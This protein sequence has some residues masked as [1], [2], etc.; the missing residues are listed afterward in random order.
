MIGKNS[1]DCSFSSQASHQVLQVRKSRFVGLCRP[2]GRGA[3]GI[4]SWHLSTIGLRRAVLGP[5]IILMMIFSLFTA[6]TP[7]GRA[8][9]PFDHVVV[10][11]LENKSLSQIYGPAPY[12][13]SLSDTYS[14]AQ[15][16]TAIDHPS[17]PNYLAMFSGLAGDCNNG[18]YTIGGC[19]TGGASSTSDCSPSSTCTMGN[20]TNLVDSLEGA[21]KTWSA[22]AEDLSTPCSGAS[23]TYPSFT[24]SR[25][26][27]FY[28]FTDITWSASRC[29]RIHHATAGTDIEMINELNGANP[30]NFVWLTPNLCNDM[31]DCSVSTG[32]NYLKNVVPNILN[33]NTFK[34]AQA[35]LFIV[36]DEGTAT[37]PSDYI[38]AVWAGPA[39]KLGY[40]STTQYTH[41]SFLKTLET[42]WGM[43][44]LVST[45]A[46]ASAMMEFFGSSPPPS[47]TVSFTYTPTPISVGTSVTFTGSVTGG[48]SPY[49]FSWNFGDGSTSSIN[50]T[51]HSYGSSGAY[52]VTLSVTDSV[53]NTGSATNTLTISSL[54]TT[55]PPIVLAR[56]Y[57]GTFYYPWYG[58]SPWRHWN[59]LGHSPPTTWASMYLPDDGSNVYNPSAELYS[60]TSTITVNRHLS[61]MNDARFDF[62]LVSWWGQGSYEDAALRLMLT[63]DSQNSSSTV[64]LAVYY[65]QEG[66]SDPTVS[67]LVSD[68]T[69]LYDNRANSTAYFTVS[70][71]TRSFPVVFVYAGATDAATYV[72]R[73]SQ[74][75][76]QM[77]AIGKPVYIALKVF[78]GYGSYATMV[79]DWYQYAP[80]KSY[81]LQTGYSAF[82]SPG[83]WEFP[84]LAVSRGHCSSP[85]SGG[86]VGLARNATQF[87]S[88]IATMNSLSP[89]QAQFLLVETFNEFH[90]GSQ[91][92]PAFLINHVETGFSQA[93]P[94]YSFSFIDIVKGRGGN[95]PPALSVPGPQSVNVGSPISFSISATDPDSP[96]QTLSLSASGLPTNASF[97]TASGIGSVTGTFS[98]TP[99]SIQVGVYT[100]TFTV[101]DNGSPPLSTINTVSITVLPL[102]SYPPVLGTIGNK[103]VNEQTLLTFTATATDL[104][105]DTLTFSIGAGAPTGAAITSSGVFTWTP[106]EAQGPGVYTV[107]IIVTDSGSPPASDSKTITITVNEVNQ[108]PV[109][110]VPGGQTVDEGV[111]L[112]FTISATDPDIP[113]ETISFSATGLPAGGAFNPLTRTFSWTPSEAQGPGGYTITFTVTDSGSPVLSNAKTVTIH[114]NEV[115]VPPVLAV[116]GAQTA[117]VG[118]TITFTVAATDPD[119]PADVITISASGLPAGASFNAAT[120]VFS[121]TP[122]SS[123]GGAYVV[124]F[125][126]VDNGTPQLSDTKTVSLQARSPSGGPCPICSVLIQTPTFWL[127]A[128]GGSLG[129]ILSMITLTVRERTRLRRARKRFSYS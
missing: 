90:E 14:L 16:Y 18:G 99:S 21:G 98:W 32:D 97:P 115:N 68:L 50:P 76:S 127:F 92:E 7:P 47:L 45:D 106:T 74:A 88:A 128:I 116:P 118:S 80:T 65:E 26:F 39:V 57:W 94:S 70:N 91:I 6:F 31:H 101:T 55:Y 42:T 121:W 125:T 77:Y 33:S 13:T 72:S 59:D 49:T 46:G 123:Q 122:S 23:G 108:P 93:V 10:I 48:T 37:Y 75:R 51:T 64:K 58:N 11:L 129:L 1:I 19:M 119:I 85:C 4:M 53:G 52:S 105:G 117:N 43:P 56:Q 17:L 81:E 83:Y 34:T 9:T 71:G 41:Y 66:T 100:I 35:A 40:K 120:G 29:G 38:Y 30:A 79:D 113:A 15:H 25:H 110:S 87:Q 20:K 44:S 73:W 67:Q 63:Q 78:T 69:Y 111:V 60:S 54:S 8:A 109:L 114:V 126:A 2:K 107:T 62:A 22:Y 28:Y 102:G 3:Q 36:F 124:T 112:S 27:P 84:E 5:L 24:G 103:V 104:D 12:M 96:A 82:A 61:W 86:Y 89:A 95:T